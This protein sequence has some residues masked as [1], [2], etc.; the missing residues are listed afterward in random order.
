MNKQNWYYVFI[1]F[2]VIMV[3]CYSFYYFFMR[4]EDKRSEEIIR[5]IEEKSKTEVKLSEVE[6]KRYIESVPLKG[7]ID[8]SI[9]DAYTK[10]FSSIEEIDETTV[11]NMVYNSLNF[12][13]KSFK[14]DIQS[15]SLENIDY[16]IKK[17]EYESIFKEELE[18]MYHLTRIPDNIAIHVEPYNEYYV[19][20]INN[21]NEDKVQK[22]SEIVSYSANLKELM[23]IEKA[24]FVYDNKVYNMTNNDS[25]VY[26]LTAEDGVF[27]SMDVLKKKVKNYATEFKHIFRWNERKNCYYWYSTQVNK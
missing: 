21:N 19:H 8:D 16:Y 1:I 13:E 11:L 23:I 14:K 10:N 5:K 27:L 9:N 7:K 3:F 17:E 24:S 15:I 2:A 25:L 20:K 26:T 12:E 18:K 4:I 6:L 22:I